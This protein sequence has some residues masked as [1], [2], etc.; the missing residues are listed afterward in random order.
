MRAGL[1]AVVLCLTIHSATAQSCPSANPNGPSKDSAPQT[2]SGKLVYHDGLRQ[3]LGLQLDAPT[4]GQ[5]EIQLIPAE[6]DEP[7]W[8]LLDVLR[9][10]RVTVQGPLGLSPTGYYS[11]DLYQ[12]AD[13]IEPGPG[14]VRQPAFPD[15]SKSKPDPSIRSYRV[16]VR[17]DYLGDHIPITARNGNR[18]LTPWQAY[19]NYQLTGGFGLY[20]FC[21]DGFD[22]IHFT[23]TPEAKPWL[24]D[25][26]LAMD[27]E[28]AAQKHVTHLR[29]DYTC[30]RDPKDA[31]SSPQ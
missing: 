21:A 6:I 5:K 23:G 22:V 17:I 13:K 1:F 7:H 4:C 2:L 30:R 10:C 18:I 15:Y 3:W 27:P 12:T 25:T 31:L 11:T 28:T 24:I 20:A 26:Y 8:R 14:C 19:A 29:L 9:G 16:A